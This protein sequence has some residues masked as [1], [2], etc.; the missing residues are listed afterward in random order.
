MALG[1][2]V[3]TR[4]WPFRVPTPLPAV[5]SSLRASGQLQKENMWGWG[6]VFRSHGMQISGYKGKDGVQDANCKSQTG[7]SRGDGV[8]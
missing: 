5:P 6:L 3:R 2:H 7:S 8:Y 4:H 1:T